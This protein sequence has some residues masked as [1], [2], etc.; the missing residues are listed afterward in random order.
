MRN[1]AISFFLCV[2]M[3]FTTGCFLSVPKAQ[4]VWGISDVSIDP[5]QISSAAKDF[6]FQVKEA[7]I[8]AA[9]KIADT[10]ANL[11]VIAAKVAAL[12]AVQK[13]VALI[14]GDDDGESQIIRDYNDYLYISPNQRA[15]AQMNTFFNTVSRGRLS[16]LNY[17]G[18]GP[19]YDIY[20]VSQA[21]QTILGTPFVTNIQDQ[22]IDPSQMF[23]GGNMK[24]LM[25]YM[26][27][28]NNVACYTVEAKNK[29]EKELSKAQD[30]ARSE[31]QNGF[32]PKKSSIGR[33]ISPAA[34]A[35]NALLQVDQ[36]G[37]NL[38]VQAPI[39][40]GSKAIQASLTQIATGATL[41]ITAR[42]INYGISDNAGKEAIKNKNEQYPFSLSYSLVNNPLARTVQ[43][44]ITTIN[45]AA[46]TGANAV[47]NKVNTT[48]Q[49]AANAVVNAAG[50]AATSASQ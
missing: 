3:I 41:S 28:A 9:E 31:Q 39:T 12:Y 2:A 30:I 15:M 18:I 33:I 42:A 46:I 43:N 45:S 26:Q 24:G 49:S 50:Q 8:R 48:T 19:N 25:A 36:M 10:A 47:V 37:T 34:L 1:K 16:Y 21:K 5:A 11:A 27:C 20:L 32:L 7:A 29:Y 23:S 35:Q 14:I 22:V 44:G 38:I 17:E 6:A 4:A 13:A 40:G